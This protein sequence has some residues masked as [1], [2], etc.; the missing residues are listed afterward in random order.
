MAGAAKALGHDHRA[1]KAL[2]RAAQTMAKADLWR[3]GLAV[4]TLRHELREAIAEAVEAGSRPCPKGGAV[5]TQIVTQNGR[6]V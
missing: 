5:V 1:T 4:K 2:A 3:A 6:R